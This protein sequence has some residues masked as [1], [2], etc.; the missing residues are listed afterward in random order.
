M[1]HRVA[2]RAEADIDDIWLYAAKES[3]SMDVATRLVD[4]ITDRFLFLASFPYAGHVREQ[5]SGMGSRS[6]PVGE[7]I[8]PYCVEGPDVSIL[9]VVCGRR[10]LENL[11][12]Q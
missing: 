12:E 8:I 10:D 4:S 11:F 3:G 5:D 2:P 6:F 7:C 1:G 9:R